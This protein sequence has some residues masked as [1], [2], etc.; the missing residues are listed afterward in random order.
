MPYRVLSMLGAILALG[1]VAAGCSTSDEDRV[2]DR[3]HAWYAD[4]AHGRGPQACGHLTDLGRSQFVA[5]EPPGEDCEAVVRRL[6]AAL[7]DEQR[8]IFERI[9]VRRVDVDANRAMV[10]GR[11][12][13]L[14]PELQALAPGWGET[15][16]LRTDNG[17]Q[18][19]QV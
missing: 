3:M 16:L 14:P 13:Q 12:V 17:W 1:G 19:D 9:K 8:S 7:S 4:V 6:G 11:D 15:V 2:K 5:G 18:I 10:R